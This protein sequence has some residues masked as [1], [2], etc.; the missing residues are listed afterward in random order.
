[1]FLRRSADALPSVSLW[2]TGSAAIGIP[3][4]SFCFFDGIILIRVITDKGLATN[5]KLLRMFFRVHFVMQTRV[6]GL[7]VID[8]VELIHDKFLSA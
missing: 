3:I 4:N 6:A 2:A 1:M 8:I 7:V 5:P